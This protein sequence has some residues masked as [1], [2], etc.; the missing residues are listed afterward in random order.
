MKEVNKTFFRTWLPGLIFIWYLIVMSQVQC[1]RNILEL[2][3]IQIYYLQ[4]ALSMYI[5][6]STKDYYPKE[7]KK[8]LMSLSLLNA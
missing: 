1:R 8:P 4:C 5:H 2:A 6:T 7:K 3:H